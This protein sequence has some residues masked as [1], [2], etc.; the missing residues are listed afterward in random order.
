[1][2]GIGK[3]ITKI[4]DEQVVG[5]PTHTRKHGKVDR[6]KDIQYMVKMLLP[7]KLFSHTLGRTFHGFTDFKICKGVRH[8]GKFKLRLLKHL[9]NM[10]VQR[11]MNMD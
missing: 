10:A 9:E 7:Q 6:K 11:D 1:M 2:L 4:F 8:P 3:Q 5:K